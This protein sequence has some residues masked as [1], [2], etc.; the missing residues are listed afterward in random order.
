[1]STHIV[2]RLGDLQNYPESTLPAFESAINKGADWLEFDVHLTADGEIVVHHFY[3]LGTTNDGDGFITD[4]TLNELKQLD[5]GSWFSPDFSGAT[6]PTLAEVLELGRGKVRFEIDMKTIDLRFL[7]RLIQI[8]HDMGLRDDVELISSQMPLLFHVKRLD[9][10]L[11]TGAFFYSLQTWM[12]LPLGQLQVLQTATLADLQ[13][14]HLN[15]SLITKPFIEELHQ[16]GFTT[17]GSNFNSE[18]AI[19]FAFDVG[20]DKF[21]TDMLD[22]ALDVRR[23][24]TN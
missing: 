12:Q 8:I 15:R 19:H 1:M 6:M 7:D 24:L 9:P 10:G 4:Y 3:Y 20:L 16:R 21:S 2:A 5:S 17:L 14:V 18:T 23:K 11:R 13:V 22:L